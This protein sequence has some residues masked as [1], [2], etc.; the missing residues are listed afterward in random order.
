MSESGSAAEHTQPCY[1]CERTFTFRELGRYEVPMD[2]GDGMAYEFVPVPLCHRCSRERFGWDCPQCGITHD[3]EDDAMFC[4]RRRPG[5]APDC[6]ECGRRMKRGAWGY[7]PVTGPTVEWA[8]C[9][10]C[11]IAWGR[12]TGWHDLDAMDGDGDE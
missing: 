9:E 12:F 11:G 6:L 1:D 5:E 7:D 8:E 2:I 4:C 3:S 10:P